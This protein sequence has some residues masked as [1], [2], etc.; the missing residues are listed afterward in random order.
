MIYLLNLKELLV[1]IHFPIL[2]KFKIIFKLI[3]NSG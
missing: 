1:F 2:G 3:F